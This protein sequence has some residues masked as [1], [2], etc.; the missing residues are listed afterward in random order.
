MSYSQF[1]QDNWVL[2]YFKKGIFVD[3]GFNDGV[4]ISNTKLLDDLGW[5]GVGIDPFPRNFDYRKNTKI[6]IGCVYKEN[7]EVEFT[8]ASDLGG[9][10][11][12]IE[13]HKSHSWV[14]KAETIKIESKT[15]EYFI[16]KNNLPKK[17]E[18]LSMDTE[19]SEYEIFSTFNFNEY[20]FGCITCEH[21]GEWEKRKK[22]KEILEKNNYIFIKELGVDDCFIHK[23]VN[24]SRF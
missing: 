16:K 14:L 7:K 17:I 6:E 15:L 9:I 2:S 24:Y 18:Y 11:E 13:A 10:K 19:G 1:G 12:H 4:T 21:N 23:S 22:I 5:S 20:T 8:C 3:V